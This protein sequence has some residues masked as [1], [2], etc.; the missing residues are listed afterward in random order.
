MEI[1]CLTKNELLIYHGDALRQDG[2]LPGIRSEDML[3]SAMGHAVNKHA[4]SECSIF[5]LA[6][7]YAFGISRNHPFLDG[8]KR[9]AGLAIVALLFKNG[10]L[11][12]P[13]EQEFIAYMLRLAAG[14]LGEEELAEWI[15]RSSRPRNES[16]E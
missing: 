3:E 6:A 4:C 10:Y 15:E 5:E 16:A 7:A 9:T 13:D 12:R 14:D 2:G 11:F 1:R 8:N